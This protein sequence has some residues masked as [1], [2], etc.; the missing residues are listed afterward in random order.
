M[1]YSERFDDALQFASDLHRDQVRKGRGV[2]YITHLL[3]VASLVGAHGGDEDQVIAALLHDAIEDCVGEVPDIAEQIEERY[4]EKVREIVEGLTDAY[5]Q[6]KP[7]WTERKQTYIDHVRE[8]PPDSPVLLVCLSD[9]MHNVRSILR[10]LRTEGDELWEI[11]TGGHGGTLWYYT[12]LAEVFDGKMEGHL[13]EEFRRLV[14]AMVEEG[15][16]PEALEM[17][18]DGESL[19]R[20]P[21]SPESALVEALQVRLD[22]RFRVHDALE[23]IIVESV[24]RGEF[25]V[26]FDADDHSAHVSLRIRPEEMDAE[27]DEETGPAVSAARFDEVPADLRQQFQEA[28]AERIGGELAGWR[29]RDFEPDEPGRL[30]SGWRA[31]L[32]HEPMIYQQPLVRQTDGLDDLVALV[33]WLEDV[34]TVR[35]ISL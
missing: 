17:V 29:D 28:A 11:F 18:P 5:Q 19:G 24:G 34:G 4:G 6:P 33:R 10:D 7:P 26:E 22:D 27:E 30:T 25:L 35:S 8:L 21:S 13:V 16:R 20:E 2:P 32:A 3:G 23:V 15:E 1:A 12:T 31:G 14:G 9:K